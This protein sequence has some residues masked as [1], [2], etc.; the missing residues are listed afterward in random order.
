MENQKDEK[1]DALAKVIKQ[2][3]GLV[4]ALIL[5]V[6]VLFGFIL[7]IFPDTTSITEPKTVSATELTPVTSTDKTNYWSPPDITTLETNPDK[8]TIL[9]GK[10]LIASTAE[11]FGPEGKIKKNST[12]GMNC[13]NCHLDAGTKVFG[14]NYGSV[15]STYPRYRAR[16]GS[17]EN[18]YKRVN[19]CFERSLNG[20]PL[21]TASKEMNAIVS[22]IHWLG[23]DVPKG[24]KA[25]GSGLKEL[26]FLDRPADPLKGKEGY[27][28]KCQSCHLA[29]GEGQLNLEKTAY[30]FPPLWGSNSYNDGAGLYRISNFAKYIKFNMPL[31]A[32]H[33]ATL[34]SDEE[35]WDIAAYVNSQPDQRKICK[36]TGRILQRNHSTILSDPMPM[37]LMKNNINMARF[38]L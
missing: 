36:K 35:A 2:L 20:Q 33:A 13:Q 27:V 15:F 8:E 26:A 14:N 6:F 17:I 28:A 7:Y 34:L 23:K 10:A 18:I 19:D 3:L 4:T 12:N 16:S 11:Y 25:A 31:G 32:S 38:N 37:A 22:Y 24:E 1:Y 29:N 5:L 9:Y 21:D 30:A